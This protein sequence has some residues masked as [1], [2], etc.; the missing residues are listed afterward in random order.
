ME[1]E[2]Y[3]A[4]M[5]SEP[6]T[7]PLTE[8]EACKGWHFCEELGQRLARHGDCFCHNEENKNNKERIRKP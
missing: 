2:R 8:E 6:R 5:D 3:T 1:P 4:L 7:L